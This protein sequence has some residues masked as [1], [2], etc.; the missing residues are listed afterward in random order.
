MVGGSALRSPPGGGPP[1]SGGAYKK[2]NPERQN[3]GQLKKM[4]GN[5]PISL[6]KIQKA[7]GQSELKMINENR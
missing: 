3:S 7:Q 5:P 2:E 4:N 6:T 1:P